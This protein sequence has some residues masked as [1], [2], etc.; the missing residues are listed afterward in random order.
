[1]IQWFQGMFEQDWWL[2]FFLALLCSL[3]ALFIVAFI[4]AAFIAYIDDMYNSFRSRDYDKM[5]GTTFVFLFV[6]SIIGVALTI[7]F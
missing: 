7:F 1:M 3:V 5:I 6:T 4:V 2:A